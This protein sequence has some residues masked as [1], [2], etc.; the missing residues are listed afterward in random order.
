MSAMDAGSTICAIAAAAALVLAGYFSLVEAA[1]ENVSRARI[2]ALEDSERRTRRALDLLDNWERS[3]GAVLIGTN[4]AHVAFAALVTYLAIRAWTLSAAAIAAACSALAV[5]FLTEAVPKCLGEKHAERVCLAASASLRFFTVLFKPLYV[6]FS[7][8]GRALAKL[9][10]GDAE[11]SV[12]EDELYDIIEDMTDQ[13]SLDSE[14]GEL[15]SSALQFADLTAE[16][17]LTARVDVAAI[18]VEWDTEKTLDFIRRERHSRLPVYSDSIDNIIGVLQ[19]R[20]Y[21]RE[22]LVN[23]GKAD[24]RAML[25]EAYFVERDMKIDKLLSLMS[26]KKLNMAIVTDGYGGTLGIVTV[27]DILEELVGEI[28]DEDDVVEETFVPLGGGRYEVDAEMP[29]GETLEKLGLDTRELP[30]EDE[31]KLLG[32]W[33]YEHFDRIPSTRESFTWGRLSVTVSEMRQNR[34]VKLV[35]RVLPEPEETAEGGESK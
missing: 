11:V 13:G 25:D 27:E 18:D 19:I 26:S 2:K 23:G 1:F 4:L 12:T 15:V 7:A 28:W 16:N 3:R 10:K 20:K 35:C 6:V 17:I 24:L 33:A 34:I 8:I 29:V 21:I 31:Y 9:T 22:Y 14:R 30:D 5:F 32:E